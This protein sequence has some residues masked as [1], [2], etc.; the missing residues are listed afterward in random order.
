MESK[1][2]NLL[3]IKNLHPDD[4]L[5]KRIIEKKETPQQI[6]EVYTE[7]PKRFTS[8]ETWPQFSNLKCWVCSRLPDS[9]PKF[10]P[11]YPERSERN[12][13]DSCDPYG[14]FD[15]WNCAVRYIERELP[16]SQRPDLMRLTCLFESKFTGRRRE[17]IMPAP[18]PALMK[19]YCG[20]N[21]ISQLEYQQMI[22][23]L[24]Q[25]YDLSS[26]KMDHFRR[27]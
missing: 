1:R 7:V 26:Y 9:Y 19:D 3:I 14:N 23:R 12:N 20:N 15:T 25:D 21:G 18:T 16:E 13:T 24:N 8:V 2:T 6:A 17:K 10:I 11:I 5:S 22:D 4:F 27:E